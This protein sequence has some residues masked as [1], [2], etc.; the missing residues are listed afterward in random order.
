MAAWPG[1]DCPACGEWMP[2]NQLHCRECRQSLNPE[3]TRESVEVPEFVPLQELDSIAEIEPSGIYC[4][5]P[6]CGSELKISRK[7]L[8]QKIQCKHCQA[9]YRLDPTGP[10]VRQADVYS[11]CTHC[12]QQL[13][14]AHKY[15]GRKVACRFCGGKLQVLKAAT[16]HS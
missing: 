13:R 10:L 8:G 1:G 15:L 5:C 11:T 14:F 9:Q 3:L 7:Y 2:P 16:A 4:D 6:K 12:R